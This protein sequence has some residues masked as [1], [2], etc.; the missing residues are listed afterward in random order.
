MDQSEVT[1]GAGR[2]LGIH[3]SLSVTVAIRSKVCIG[4]GTESGAP[5]KER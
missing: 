4:P 5:A 1:C 2:L 3:V